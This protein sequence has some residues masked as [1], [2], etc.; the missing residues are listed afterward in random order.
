M[1]LWRH[2]HPKDP[3]GEGRGHTPADRGCGCGP[4]LGEANS[5]GAGGGAIATADDATATDAAGGA[6]APLVGMW[7]APPLEDGPVGKAPTG[8]RTGGNAARIA[9]GAVAGATGTRAETARSLFSAATWMDACLV[10][11]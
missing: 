3:W 9:G 5:D 4:P 6:V 1:S 2:N 10:R 7:A 11:W 8:R